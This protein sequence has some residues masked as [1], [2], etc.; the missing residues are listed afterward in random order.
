MSLSYRLYIPVAC[1]EEEY[2]ELAEKH[3]TG[4]IKRLR[5][6]KIIN[7]VYELYTFLI[8]ITRRVD[9][10]NSFSPLRSK[11]STDTPTK[12]WL[13]DQRVSYSRGN[14]LKRSLLFGLNLID[15]ITLAHSLEVAS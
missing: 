14:R 4:R 7:V 2:I 15:R 5:S 9:L 10:T 6:Y 1:R 11:F 3:V 8:R 12:C 13:A